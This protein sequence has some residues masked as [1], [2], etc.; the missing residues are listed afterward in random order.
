MEARGLLARL[1]VVLAPQHVGA[2][3][4]AAQRG[5][6]TSLFELQTNERAMDDFLRGIEGQQPPGGVDRFLPPSGANL[7][8]QE[9]AEDRQ[10]G[11]QECETALGEPFIEGWNAGRK[12]R[13]QVPAKN[14]GRLA[15]RVDRRRRD[16]LIEAA[17][18]DVDGLPIEADR[19]TIVDEDVRRQ[20]TK[21]VVQIAN[22]RAHLGFRSRIAKEQRAE[23]RDRRL[24]VDFQR[25]INDER[26]RPPIP[27]RER[28]ASIVDGRKV[29]EQTDG[30]E[31][32]Y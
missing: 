24:A 31:D 20:K 19:H 14:L 26:L 2:F 22:D 27:N 10:R 28:I 17:S 13:Q 6:G 30:E 11:A 7:R 4:I 18:V 25:Q 23:L 3:L 12:V 16:Q 15:D 1:A 8:R 9:I 32:H 21:R 5:V 29:T